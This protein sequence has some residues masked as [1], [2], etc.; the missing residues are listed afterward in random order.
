MFE[1][2]YNTC[3]SSMSLKRKYPVFQSCKLYLPKYLHQE[4]IR[5]L[6]QWILLAGNCSKSLPWAKPY[7]NQK[8]SFWKSKLETRLDHLVPIPLF[9]L[10]LYIQ[11]K[12]THSLYHRHH[13]CLLPHTPQ[14][15]HIHVPCLALA[16]ASAYAHLSLTT[17]VRGKMESQ[18]QKKRTISPKS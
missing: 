8:D 1:K 4:F 15:S 3:Q 13:N 12:L 10:L 5:V 17:L 16:L 14:I 6:Q 18:I 7:V 9:G 2:I 11:V